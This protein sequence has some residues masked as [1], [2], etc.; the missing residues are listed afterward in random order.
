MNLTITYKMHEGIRGANYRSLSARDSEGNQVA[1]SIATVNPVD[2]IEHAINEVV[3]GV[4][5]GNK[6]AQNI[7]VNLP[8]E[9]VLGAEVQSSLVAKATVDPHVNSLT[10]A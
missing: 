1:T 7:T 6:A 4:V 10:F 3:R 2:F 8:S 9:I 5:A